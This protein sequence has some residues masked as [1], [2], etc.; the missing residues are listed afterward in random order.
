MY[1]WGVSFISL[2]INSEFLKATK[3]FKKMQRLKKASLLVKPKPKAPQ[4]PYSKW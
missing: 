2:Y 3:A 4:V 1:L